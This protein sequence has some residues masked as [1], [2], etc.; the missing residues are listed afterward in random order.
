[1]DQTAFGRLLRGYTR[2]QISRY[3]KED[4]NPPIDFFIKLMRTFGVDLNWLFTG[5]GKPYTLDF[6]DSEERARFLHW[7][8][9]MDERMEFL[10]DI[11]G[12]TKN[13]K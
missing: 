11:S 7:T 2:S 10:N 4:A 3:E 8:Y 13:Y 12:D 6:Q 9:L 5:V 1:M